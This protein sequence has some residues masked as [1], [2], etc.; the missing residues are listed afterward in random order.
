MKKQASLISF[1]K[2]SVSSTLLISEKQ[3]TTQENAKGSGPSSEKCTLVSY[4]HIDSEV[5]V[6]SGSR[7]RKAL[8]SAREYESSKRSRPFLFKWKTMFAWI[9]YDTEKDEMYCIICRKF[10]HVL[11]VEKY[12]KFITGSD[13]FRIEGLRSHESS[14]DH[15]QCMGAKLAQE[16]PDKTPKNLLT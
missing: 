3:T 10:K 2:G 7:K 1:F 6:E 8:D 4:K 11:N 16:H 9:E 14:P 15:K 5:K 13:T 12:S